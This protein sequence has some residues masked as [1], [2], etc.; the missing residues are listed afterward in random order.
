MPSED[1]P[2]KAQLMKRPPAS[3]HISLQ[4]ES[5]VLDDSPPQDKK[6]YKDGGTGSM[7]PLPSPDPV[8]VHSQIPLTSDGMIGAPEDGGE[9]PP[10][11]EPPVPELNKT[12][13][14]PELYDSTPPPN[15]AETSSPGEITSQTSQTLEQDTSE[16]AGGSVEG[17]LPS[18][19]FQSVSMQPSII[20]SSENGE[21]RDD[22]SQNMDKSSE[23]LSIS[24][25]TSTA[26]EQS[27]L[28]AKRI[29]TVHS[30]PLIQHPYNSSQRLPKSETF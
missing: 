3:L 13:N 14:Q 22:E 9:W 26:C 18:D 27:Q 17:D 28:P 1:T 20:S 24:P 4:Q 30:D 11:Y 19:N 7:S 2:N 21:V 10:P 5:I 8:L 12:Q 23:R 6:P 15:V 16:T 29:P 25:K